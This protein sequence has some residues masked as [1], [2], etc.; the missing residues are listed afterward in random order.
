MWFD[1]F[2]AARSGCGVR[3]E[4]GRPWATIKSVC[5]GVIALTA[6]AAAP[7]E[8]ANVACK[9]LPNPIYG[10]GGSAHVPFFTKYAKVLRNLTEADG[11]PISV[12]YQSPGACVAMSAFKD[13]TKPGLLTGTAT[14]WDKDGKSQTCDLPLEGEPVDFGAMG[15]FPQ[16]CPGVSGLPDGVGDW[17]GVINSWNVLVPIAS[18]ELSISAEAFYFIFGFGAAGQVEPWTDESQYF[19]RNKTSAASLVWQFA[20][21]LSVEK[22]IGTD[23]KTNQASITSLAESKKPEAAI[24]Y[25]SGEVADDN[26]DKV[27][28]LAW[29]HFDQSAGYYPD[30]SSTAFDK[31]GVRDGLYYI[32]SSTHLFAWT[33]DKG[34]PKDPAVAKFIGWFAG[35]LPAPAS[36]NILDLTIANKNVPKC[37]MNVWRDGDMAPLYSYVPDAPCGCYFDFK[38]TGSTT[39]T[40]CT[41]DNECGG[42]KCR[43]GFCEVK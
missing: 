34:Q 12:V 36:V 37:A 7:A 4:S 11:G 20:T 18:P 41:V 15:V 21:G 5:A 35:T 29:Q 40:A 13:K 43:H 10:T 14:Y 33:D 2:A 1:S 32:W 28:T 24:A 31:R 39:C 9:D 8:A 30:S 16:S 22:F 17:Q 6:L 26:R 38:A 3:A 27:R 19:I 25:T 23:V 42:G